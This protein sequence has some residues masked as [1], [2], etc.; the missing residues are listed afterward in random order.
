MLTKEDIESFGFNL[1]NDN[2]FPYRGNPW[3]DKYIKDKY[4]LL[5]C[6]ESLVLEILKDISFNH[7]EQKILQSFCYFI[8]KV[9]N[10]SELKILLNCIIN[11]IK[12]NTKPQLIKANNKNNE[13]PRP[14]R[15]YQ[16]KQLFVSGIGYDEYGRIVIEVRKKGN[17]IIEVKNPF[18]YDISASSFESAISKIKKV[19]RKRYISNS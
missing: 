8:G 1:N 9:Q 2:N 10:K 5:Y 14:K 3:T 4:T 6:S 18:I 15:N 17:R 13:D 11:P 7:E 16:K 19:A 12:I